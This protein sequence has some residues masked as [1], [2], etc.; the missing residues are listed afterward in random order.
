M[1]FVMHKGKPH[2]VPM[3]VLQ[4]EKWQLIHF[5]AA[6]DEAHAQQEQNTLPRCSDQVQWEY[7]VTTAKCD[8]GWHTEGNNIC[9]SA[10]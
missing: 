6:H 10:V 2:L 9:I 4:D 7:Q 8:R 5:A 3:S 1:L